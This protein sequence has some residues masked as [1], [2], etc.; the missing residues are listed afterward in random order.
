VRGAVLAALAALLLAGCAAQQSQ[1][2]VRDPGDLPQRARVAGVPFHP[3]SEHYCG[4]ASLAMVLGWAGERTDQGSI[5]PEVFTP[6]KAGTFRADLLAAARRRG[7]LAVPVT[8]LRS[9]MREL[10][11]GHPVLVF[12]N[13]GLSWIPRWHFAVA[14]G[15]DLPAAEIILHT[16][17]E[18][19]RPV[20]LATFERTWDRAGRWGMVV[21]T[22]GELPAAAD[23]VAV[24]RSAVGLEQA[25]RY[26]AAEAAY[27]AATRRWPGR[28][29]GWVG[30]ANARYHRGDPAGAEAAL[31]SALERHPRSAE[32]WNNLAVVLA[33]QGRRAA[34]IRAAE[35]AVRLGEGTSRYRRTLREVRA[36]GR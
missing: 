31:R 9:L 13:L 34:A 14:I 36:G 1:R 19:A 4:P 8:G 17:R 32:A 30:L 35:R 18:R 21:L 15:Y 7:Y 3:Q 27:A 22:P 33:E 20:A 24:L 26:G 10:A 11:A 2:L 12:Q 16:G 28:L 6:G 23:P 5:A 29:G 25:G